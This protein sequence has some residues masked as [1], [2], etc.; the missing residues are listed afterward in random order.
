M[1]PCDEYIRLY[2]GRFQE[3]ETVVTEIETE[4]SSKQQQQLRQAK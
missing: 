2:Y 3:T 1:D 4:T